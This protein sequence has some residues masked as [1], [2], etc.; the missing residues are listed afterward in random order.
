MPQYWLMK[1]EPTVYSI[2]DLAR[3]RMTYWD[4]V[5]NYQARNF[6]RDQMKIG[7]L[8]LFY[9][10]NTEPSG[11]AGIAKICRTGYPDFDCKSSKENPLWFMADIAFVKKIPRYVSLDELKKNSSLKDMLVVK[12][13]SQLSV[14]PVLKEHFDTV[15]RMGNL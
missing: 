10:S 7:N 4:G 1:S 13:C 9:H 14:Q 8:V 11:V 12:R 6:M 15:C 5:R 2:D 3:D